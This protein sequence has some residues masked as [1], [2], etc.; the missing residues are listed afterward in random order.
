MTLFEFVCPVYLYWSA[1]SLILDRDPSLNRD[2]I[3]AETGI[4][5]ELAFGC[6]HKYL[7]R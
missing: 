4:E 3:E 1:V 2:Q 6:E 5:I 7:P